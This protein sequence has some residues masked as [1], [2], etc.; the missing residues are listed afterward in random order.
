MKDSSKIKKHALDAISYTLWIRKFIIYICSITLIMN[1]ISYIVDPFYQFRVRD[2]VYFNNVR[3]TSPGLIKNYDYNTLMLGSSM[4]QNFDMK[5]FRDKLGG[6]PLHIG[7]GGLQL[8]D[9]SKLL[10]LAYSSGKAKIFY[11]CIDPSS[12]ASE[13]DDDLIPQ[14]LID[15]DL[16]SREKYFLNYESWFRLMPIDIALILCKK[17]GVSLPDK[18]AYRTKIDYF[19]NWGFEEKTGE[20][21]VISNYTNENYTVSDINL[22]SLHERMTKRINNFLDIVDADKGEHIFFFPPY[23]ALFWCD[24]QKN[25]YYEAYQSAKIYFVKMANSL[26]CTVY[27]FQ[28]ADC[29]MDLNNYK[30]TT[31]YGPEINNWMIDCF[32]KNYGI[33]NENGIISNCEN[34]NDMVERF[35]CNY[36]YLFE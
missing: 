35:R 32:A 4:I 9:M 31:H 13:S 34:L 14:F 20:D 17:I 8:T 23:S 3:M 22:D 30:D 24:A 29:I 36:Q 5:Y 25:G 27:D 2:E 16:I 21:V 1:V 10:K 33:V 6:M 11:I 26:G 18:I 15:D 28:S 19:G 7:I 12:F